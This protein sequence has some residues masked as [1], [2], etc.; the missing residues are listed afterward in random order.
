MGLL[1]F[2]NK[3][4]ALV[5]IDVGS[6]GIRLI[7]L[8]LRHGRP[9]VVNF[10]FAQL[11]GDIF[12]GNSIS[13]SELVAENL[14]GLL[15]SLAVTDKRAVTAV[16][17]PSVFT[18]RVKM[19][20]V[21]ANELRSTIYFE[22]GNFIPHNIDAV[23]LDYHVVGESTKNQLDVILVAVK[24]EVIDSYT[25]TLALS[26]LE[27]AVVDV[28]YF[29]VQNIF[30]LAHP[31]L[32]ERTVALVNIG[33]RFCAINIVSNGESL[34]TGDIAIGGK[35]FTDAI[36]EVLSISP[37]EAEEVKRQMGKPG[38]K[39][40]S[41]QAILNDSV[42]DI[43]ERNVEYMA[44]ELN[45]QITFFWNASGSEG[46]IDCIVVTGG[47]ALIPGLIEDI[48][49]KTGLE[50]LLLDPIPTVDFADGIDQTK[51]REM[52]NSLSVCLGLG[53]RQAGDRELPDIF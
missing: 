2:L 40:D 32:V 18:K 34:F 10:G 8:D 22:A 3:R 16:P 12:A 4:E 42:Q 52:A 37:Q 24:N 31:E 1:S 39:D 47:G 33:A 43:I 46:A 44:S 41:V 25:D 28:D 11:S 29:A 53:L 13:K 23:K 17:A 14:T 20:K 9:K 30:E 26:G 15:E 51:F 19:A 38:K 27:T 5:S 48:K 21:P 36:A 50:T 45:R 7:E 49:E 35:I 6:T